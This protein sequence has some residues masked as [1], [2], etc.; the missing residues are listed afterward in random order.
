ML[1]DEST[2]EKE[3]STG[4]KVMMMILNDTYPNW[5]TKEISHSRPR[6]VTKLHTSHYAKYFTV[7]SQ[8]GNIQ[9]R[10]KGSN[11]WH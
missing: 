5:D 2:D 6:Y 3:G 10:I 8:F 11:L 9:S 4:I 1:K 7:T